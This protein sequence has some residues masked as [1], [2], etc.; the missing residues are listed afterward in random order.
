MPHIYT[1]QKAPE[2]QDIPSLMQWVEQEFLAIQQSMQETRELELRPS[3]AEPSKPRE[4]MIVYADGTLWNP[5]S[6][7]GPYVYRNGVWVALIATGGGAPVGAS[8]VVM[9]L[10]G[11]L[12]AERNLVAGTG[13]AVTDGGANA[14]VTVAMANMAA[15]TVKVRN[16]GSAG[17]PSDAD[18]AALTAGTPASGDFLLGWES[19]G[20]LRKFDVG[21]LPAGGG[22]GYS[23]HSQALTDNDGGFAGAFDITGLAGLSVD[24]DVL[25]QEIPQNGVLADETEMDLV[26][27]SGKAISTTAIR[28][29]WQTALDSGPMNRTVRFA[30]RAI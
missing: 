21:S 3:F 5:G 15:W 2:A 4:G 10:D 16:A 11:T 14:A 28:V 7:E 22:S 25:V 12:T 17:A 24:Q 6:G 18:S 13:I 20:E 9:A 30:Y 29:F 27:A 26:L 8:Y 23:T 19:T 1:P